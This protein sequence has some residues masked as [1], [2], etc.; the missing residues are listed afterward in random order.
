MGHRY[1][2]TR[3]SQ[4]LQKLANGRQSRHPINAKLMQF[5]PWGAQTTETSGS[6]IEA[7]GNKTSKATRTNQEI[8]DGIEMLSGFRRTYRRTNW[9]EFHEEERRRE[10]AK[11]TTRTAVVMLHTAYMH[12]WLPWVNEDLGKHVTNQLIVQLLS[13]VTASQ[14]ACRSRISRIYSQL[15][16]TAEWSKCA[17]K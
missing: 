10:S 17:E 3:G 4:R 11:A 15:F 13:S 8:I 6:Q 14:L 2:K 1:D 9:M 7:F 12:I 5:R 16:T